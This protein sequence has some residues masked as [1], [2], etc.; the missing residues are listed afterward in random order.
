MYSGTLDYT[1]VIQ[2]SVVLN[3]SIESFTDDGVGVL[4]GDGS[5][6]G[7][8]TV[9][10]DDGSWA[11]T[12]GTD[13]TATANVTASYFSGDTLNSMTYQIV[14]DY[15][16]NIKLPEMSE[17]DVGFSKIYT[18][19]IRLID[20]A[21]YNASIN[22]IHVTNAS[23]TNASINTVKVSSYFKM[24]TNQYM[25]FGIKNSQASIVAVATNVDA[26]CK[27]SLYVSK[28]GAL[29]VLN[30]D[31]TAIKFSTGV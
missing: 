12:L 21:H 16:P 31:T 1:P 13:L 5:P 23:I 14:T 29:W 10:Y 9:S 11:I 15:T 22:S 17:N 24:G 20:A 2:S 19:A 26:S 7:S 4:T 18:K 6:A 8:G 28:Q 3:A 27:G 25:L 30:S